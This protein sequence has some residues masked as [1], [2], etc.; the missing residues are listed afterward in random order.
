MPEPDPNEPDFDPIE[1][2]LAEYLAATEDERPPLLARL[3]AEQPEAAKELERRL[4]GL[5]AI[6]MIAD[7]N[8]AGPNF[9]GVPERLGDFRLIEKLGGGGMGV[10]Y[11]AEQSSLGREVALK[12]VRPE[13]LFFPGARERFRREVEAVA[14]LKHPG[15]VPVYTVGEEHGLPYFAMERIEGA[16]LADVLSELSGR[17]SESLT[18]ADFARALGTRGKLAPADLDATA[19]ERGWLELVVG[20]AAEIADALDHAHAHGILHRDVKPSN[21]AMTRGGRAMLLD[22]GLT[23]SAEADRITR[24]GTQVGTLYY[25][26]PEQVSGDALDARTDVYSLGA[27]LYELL[28]LRVPFQAE[29]RVKTE[30]A[31]RAGGALPAVRFNRRVPADLDVVLAKA[32]ALA[33]RDRYTSAAAFARD[34]RN[35]LERRPIEARPPGPWLRLMRFVQRDPTLASALAL[36]VLLF[37]GAPS[38]LLV[39]AREHGRDVEDRLALEQK[40]RADADR[41]TANAVEQVRR[42]QQVTELLMSIFESADPDKTH[43]VEI[44]ARELLDRGIEQVRGRLSEQPATRASLLFVLGGV[45]KQLSLLE[46][47]AELEGEGYEAIRERTDLSPS[48]TAEPISNYANTLQML[49]QVERA[50]ELFELSVEQA[51]RAFGADDA[52]TLKMRASL[53]RAFVDLGRHAEAA[54]AFAEI[55][56]KLRAANAEPLVLAQALSQAATLDLQCVQRRLAKDPKAA[57]ASAEQGLREA[58]ELYRRTTDTPTMASAGNALSLG[59]TLKLQGKLDEAEPMYRRAL[60]HFERATGPS[61]MHVGSVLTNLAGLL[62]ARG[63]SGDGVPLLER[64]VAIF[65]ETLPPGHESTVLVQGNLANT[66]IR[67]GDGANAWFELRRVLPDQERVFGRV[68]PIVGSTHW[69]LAGLARDFADVATARAHLEAAF[70]IDAALYGEASDDALA[71]RLDLADASLALKDVERAQAELEAVRGL[72][73]DAEPGTKTAQRLAPLSASIALVAGDA[74]AALAESRAALATAVDPVLRLK[75]EH[76]LGLALLAARDFEGA[77]EQLATG[78]SGHGQRVGDELLC[79]RCAASLLT[80]LE[81]AGRSDEARELAARIECAFGR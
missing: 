10:V 12:L 59:L 56:P 45:Y 13:H 49:G 30:D 43:G 44:T 69:A 51:T 72:L 65:L 63:K 37:V 60:E 66:R 29:N 2:R 50:R 23:S 28:A 68:S 14:R 18:G 40:L 8:V 6:G 58:D 31:I 54:A 67:A 9:A 74:E 80:A 17:A 64:A 11:R 33:P 5:R 70:A 53:A 62:D 48:D 25:M 19:F 38:A 81:G 4:A 1:E 22:F 73:G 71:L 46:R 32:M 34:L 35:V 16:T 77:R 3:A 26:S 47:A 36:G 41:A 79:R 61:S 20:L 78:V 57:L 75:L 42:H 15:I 21:V 24:S 27:T 52:R 76:V 7:S 39:Q 55:V